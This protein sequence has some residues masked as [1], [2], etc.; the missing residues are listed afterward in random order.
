MSF[1]AR[2]LTSK[3]KILGRLVSSVERSANPALNRT[4]RDMAAQ[5]RLALRVCQA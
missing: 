4:L 1:T 5:R 2:L 3:V